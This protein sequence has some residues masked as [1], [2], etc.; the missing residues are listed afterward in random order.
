VAKFWALGHRPLVGAADAL[1][2]SQV[3]AARASGAGRADALWSVTLPLMRP[4]IIGAWLVVFLL[5]LHELT[6]S[7]LLH[8]P[9][10]RTLAVVILDL[11]QLGDV[12]GTS[13]LGILLTGLAL[14][15]GAGALLLVR[16]A[17]P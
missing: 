14:L 7:S 10:T 8:G 9:G 6:M 11:Q 15:V 12:P 13:A 4:A 3:V 5:S 16:R 2:G 17:W 1:A